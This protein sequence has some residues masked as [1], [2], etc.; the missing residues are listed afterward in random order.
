MNEPM[1]SEDAAMR[2][3]RK[4]T[5]RQHEALKAAR[6]ATDGWI[7]RGF[8]RIWG[9]APAAAH[10]LVKKGYLEMPHGGGRARLTPAGRS[11]VERIMS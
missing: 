10:A 4:L 9:I 11:L 5:P 3:W 2:E 1:P 7:Q 6:S 8:S